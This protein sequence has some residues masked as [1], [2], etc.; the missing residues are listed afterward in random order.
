MSDPSNEANATTDPARVAARVIDL[1]AVADGQ[2]VIN[3]HWSEPEEDGGA[4][5][6][7]LSD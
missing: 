4:S 2:D 6:T 1:V 7:G 5:I 3:L